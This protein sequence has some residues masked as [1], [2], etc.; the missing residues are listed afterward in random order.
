MILKIF[1]NRQILWQLVLL[2][3]FFALMIS[4]PVSL[5]P[6]GNYNP[7]YTPVYQLLTG[8]YWLTYTFFIVL[9]LSEIVLLQLLVNHYRLI[10]QD[11][12][13]VVF[14]W[15]LLLFSN[16]DM[17]SVSP[18]LI[19]SVISTW[20]LYK[21]LGFSEQENKL[22]V[23]FSIGFIFSVASLFYSLMLLFFIV[24]ILATIVLSIANWRE[25]AVLFISLALP[26]LYLY[27]YAF[28]SGESIT[29]LTGIPS[30]A[31]IPNWRGLLQT[32]W[33]SLLIGFLIFLLALVSLLGFYMNFLYKL[34]QIRNY[35]LVLSMM[36][37]FFIL[38]Q[39]M[40][41]KFWLVHA[42]LIFIPLSIL[43]AMALNDRPKQRF[44]NLL[45]ILIL[46][47]EIFQRFY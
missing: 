7:L 37:A 46:V 31:A 5:E 14:I 39:F 36:L 9:V 12:F 10:P 24:L 32:H 4:R 42:V 16:P 38:V 44:S 43:L 19:T 3:V 25:L 29:Y 6:P 8:H 28:V 27:V 18:V 22:A 34:I 45:I 35:V 23:L 30:Q 26:Y 2:V 17:M 13:L 15:L 1:H 33:V 20:G 40:A 47:L 41:G 11:N 21:L